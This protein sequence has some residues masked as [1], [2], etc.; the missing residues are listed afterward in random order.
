MYR[1]CNVCVCVDGS[2]ERCY[3]GPNRG[4]VE[5]SLPEEESVSEMQ[6][7]DLPSGVDLWGRCFDDCEE[8]VVEV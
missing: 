7:T 8:D 5:F 3:L 1:F 6:E 4:F 2:C